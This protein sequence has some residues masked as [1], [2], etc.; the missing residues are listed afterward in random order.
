MNPN[1][2]IPTLCFAVLVLTVA[3][4]ARGVPAQTLSGDD[5]AETAAGVS[6]STPFAVSLWPATGRPGIEDR[7]RAGDMETFLGDRL[8]PLLAET[9]YS[10][11]RVHVLPSWDAAAGRIREEQSHIIECDPA[12][13]FLTVAARE[14]LQSRYRVVLQSVTDPMPRGLVLAPRKLGITRPEGLQ[15]RNVAFLHRIAGG[16]AQ[17]QRTLND[18]GLA[19]NRDYSFL[20]AGY[21]ENA[22]RNL[23]LEKGPV[24]AIAVSS[25]IVESHLRPEDIEELATVLETDEIL[26]PLFA[27][28]RADLERF[29]A[30]GKGLVEALRAFSG[31]DRI[32]LS[33]DDLYERAKEEGLPWE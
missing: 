33:G 7:A 31:P 24:D 22:L 4:A 12:L 2:K 29:P 14:R 9:G 30:F 8:A 10:S 1:R 15:G 25:E 20:N 6:D 18:L 11:I 32:V 5:P 27:G 23:T 13:Y 28:R 21:L 3:A 17:I 16:A 19:V 26:P